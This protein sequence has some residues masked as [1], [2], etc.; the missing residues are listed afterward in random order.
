MKFVRLAVILVTPKGTLKNDSWEAEIGT[1]PT[2]V[3]NPEP[4]KILIIFQAGYSFR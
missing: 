3:P 1:E 4:V 2:L